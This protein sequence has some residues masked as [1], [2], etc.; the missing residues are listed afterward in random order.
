MASSVD[1]P[2]AMPSG[3]VALQPTLAPTVDHAAPVASPSASVW[4]VRPKSG[5]QYG[6]ATDE[7]FR[8]WIREGRVAADAHVWRD[9][10][11]DWRLARDA[12]GE[13]PVPLDELAAPTGSVGAWPVPGAAVSQ[14]AEPPKVAAV[15]PDVPEVGEAAMQPAS[16][17]LASRKR[18]TQRQML[19]AVWMLVAI[20]VLTGI[21]AW[22]LLRG[23]NAADSANGAQA[24][25][26]SIWLA[27]SPVATYVAFSDYG[28]PGLDCKS[29]S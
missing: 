28:L 9:G 5:G 24:A 14:P 13:L 16:R 6:P 2:V 4:Y 22:V 8:H 7:V 3:V 21:L 25:S 11:S 15:S 19:I 26:S 27:E 23:D 1:L 18:A 12:S 29:A 17:Y 20:V 10:W